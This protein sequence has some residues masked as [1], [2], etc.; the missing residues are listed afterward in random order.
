MNNAEIDQAVRSAASSLA[1]HEMKT[2]HVY[3][4]VYVHVYHNPYEPVVPSGW[5]GGKARDLEGSA[6]V[7]LFAEA[8]GMESSENRYAFRSPGGPPRTHPLPLS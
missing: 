1:R 8:A 7:M 4:L 5:A 6:D 2:E 3:G